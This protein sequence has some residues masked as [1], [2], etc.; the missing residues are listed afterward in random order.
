[1]SSSP[2][3]LQAH[4][5]LVARPATDEEEDVTNSIV[6]VSE[7]DNDVSSASMAPSSEGGETSDGDDTLDEFRMQQLV[8]QENLLRSI[9]ARLHDSMQRVSVLR[10]AIFSAN[11]VATSSSALRGLQRSSTTNVNIVAVLSELSEVKAEA[12]HLLRRSSSLGRDEHIDLDQSSRRRA[13]GGDARRPVR[14]HAAGQVGA[15]PQPD[16]SV[17]AHPVQRSVRI[18]K[19]QLR[20]ETNRLARA[21]AKIRD[22]MVDYL[23]D[24]ED[25]SQNNNNVA[26]CAPALHS[27]AGMIPRTDVV[28]V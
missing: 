22:L 9:E 8:A 16:G 3:D 6:D 13:A 2:L 21:I 11:D 4:Q 7:A 28:D 24:D 23:S 14:T 27:S 12:K 19:R 1:M 25:L 15:T 26:T 20:A 10:E 17:L 18:K 5:Q